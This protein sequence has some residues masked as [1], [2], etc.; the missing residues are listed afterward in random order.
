MQ[1]TLGTVPNGT[2]FT[3]TTSPSPELDATNLVIGRVVEGMD[4]VRSLQGLPTVKDNNSSP[5]FIAAK[6]FGDKRADVAEKGFGKPFNKI[7]VS[8]GGLK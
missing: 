2:A 7:M 4:F 3:I 6:A 5:F 8:K 1:D